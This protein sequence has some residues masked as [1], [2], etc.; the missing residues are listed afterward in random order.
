MQIVRK[1]TE[2]Y[3]LCGDGYIKRIKNIDKFT[4]NNVMY[5][6]DNYIELFPIIDG[7]CKYGDNFQ[8][9]GILRYE[10]DGG[11]YYSNDNPPTL[12]TIQQIGTIF[13][14]PSDK[15]LVKSVIGLIDS[16]NIRNILGLDWN[17]ST[18]TPA[19]G[20]PF[21][22]YS[23]EADNHLLALNQSNTITHNVIAK[24]DGLIER[25]KILNKNKRNKNINSF[26]DCIQLSYDNRKISDERNRNS[27]TQ[28]ISTI[29]ET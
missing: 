11:K 7:R 26:E 22:P 18:N 12:G 25:D 1:A 27:K 24:W 4:S 20:L 28:I 29:V 14:I 21:Y 17:F 6:N 8:N 3:A 16:E 2:A 23:R 15:K 19:N 9:G 5:M 10:L 13:F